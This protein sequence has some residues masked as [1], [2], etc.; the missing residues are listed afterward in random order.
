VNT[1]TDKQDGLFDNR[2]T[3]GEFLL[4]RSDARKQDSRL[5]G[6]AP[7]VPESIRTDFPD[8]HVGRAFIEHVARELEG[9]DRFSAMAIRMDR[10]ETPGQTDMVPDTAAQLIPILKPID[11]LAGKE[12]G[13]WGLIDDDLVGVCFAGMA[14]GVCLALAE[15][16]QNQLA[17]ARAGTVTI[18]VA[19][20]P[21]L[22]Y[23]KREI[24]DNA[25]KAVDHAAFFGPN[26]RVVFDSVSLNISGD[27]RYQDGDIDGAIDDYLRALELDPANVNVHNSLGVCHGVLGS[28]EEAMSS[29]RSAAELGPAEAM[30]VYNQGLV[31]M[32]KGNPSDALGYFQEAR[33]ISPDLFETAYQMGKCHVD[34]GDYRQAQTHLLEAV[35][36]NPE[37]APAWRFLGE[38]HAAL[39]MADEAVVAYNNAIKK[40]PNDAEALSGLGHLYDG[41]DENTEVA[42]V[43][44]QQSVDISPENGLFRQ[45]LGRLY[46]KQDRLE[47]ALT[48]FISAHERGYDSTSLIDETRRR[49]DGDSSAQD[50]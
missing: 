27:N 31:Q 6:V 22:R 13:I 16:L 39:D 10:R 5:V 50:I 37:S 3:T 23:G 35:G 25:L 15:E 49:Q 18:G 4:N 44:C 14:D 24:L 21:T 33:D 28:F 11:R 40:N 34:L 20:Y 30:P 7:A 26:S 47:E 1:M 48:A 46:L 38:C 8:I 45:R 9:T 19:H 12:S 43:F 29:F 17:E 2:G 42:T 41:R 32:L 36:L